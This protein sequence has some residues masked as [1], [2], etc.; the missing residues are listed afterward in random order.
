MGRQVSFEA[1][2]AREYA[3]TQVQQ[4]PS[5]KKARFHGSAWVFLLPKGVLFCAFIVIPSLYT[6]V[7]MFQRGTILR[8][9]HFVGLTNFQTL[10]ADGL[11][12][13]TLEHTGLYMIV[14]I[15]LILG[16]SMM[17]GLLFAS[18]IPGMKYYRA[19]IYLPSLLSVVSTS[20]IWKILI[21]PD[22]GLLYKVF[23]VGLGWHIPW[24]S[25]GIVA[26]LFIALITLWNSLGFYSVIF[27]AGFNDIPQSL[28]EAARID[29]VNG[30]QLFWHIK[31]PLVKNVTQIVLVLL[32]INTVQV[33]DTIFVLTS[34]G[35][36]TS[37]YTVMW[38]IYQNVF[39]GGSVGYAAAMGVIILVL[40]LTL[41][42][43]FM[44]TTR[45][46]AYN[47]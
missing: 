27:M 46:E 11:F 12:L 24:L 34:G 6:F 26:I 31:L 36:G 1:I 9:F 14:A 43:I 17:V 25:N 38:Y 30:W 35:P 44:R 42:A 8:G 16:C 28:C 7:L 37:T 23:N 33:F 45:S 13:Q 19:L 41:T 21:D 4:M 32:T 40:T 20:L 10:F 15:P 5:R 18:K 39:G 3:P 29:G 47:V 2:A 22:V